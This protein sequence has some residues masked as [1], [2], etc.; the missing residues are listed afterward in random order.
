MSVELSKY[1]RNC[2]HMPKA[3]PA[4]QGNAFCP[5]IMQVG[6]HVLVHYLRNDPSPRNIP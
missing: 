1:E 3:T 4:S 5:R 2:R 6:K